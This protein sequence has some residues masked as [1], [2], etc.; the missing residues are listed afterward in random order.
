MK[1]YDTMEGIELY[2]HRGNLFVKVTQLPFISHDLQKQILLKDSQF[3]PNEDALYEIMAIR[4]HYTF[5]TAN[6]FQNNFR[7]FREHIYNVLV[8]SLSKGTINTDN[9]HRGFESLENGDVS[10]LQFFYNCGLSMQTSLM[11]FISIVN[12]GVISSPAKEGAGAKRL[13]EWVSS[14][15]MFLNDI[16]AAYFW[17]REKKQ[18]LP[19]S[20]T[21][22]A[23][24]M[25]D[26][27]NQNTSGQAT[28][29]CDTLEKLIEERLRI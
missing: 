6:K 10:V 23:S 28:P 22:V 4:C 18:W 24:I 26:Y 8:A 29:T 7:K 21:S 2:Q 17:M 1:L 14:K 16:E 25:A 11:S 9:L 15:K 20:L 19:S 12:N 5:N 3:A 13:T 27:L